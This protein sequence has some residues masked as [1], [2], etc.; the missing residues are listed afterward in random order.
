MNALKLKR[1]FSQ[2][3]SLLLSMVMPGL[4]Q[5]YMD[6]HRSALLMYIAGCIFVLLFWAGAYAT[7]A[8]LMAWLVLFI[9]YYLF[10]L[11]HAFYLGLKTDPNSRKL[12]QRWMVCLTAAC[13]HFSII[14]V[15]IFCFGL[16]VKLYR[17][18]TQSMTP[19]LKIGDYFLIDRAID[20][21]K[22]LQR[23]D[24]V[25]FASPTNPDI[26]YVKRVVGLP[27]EVVEVVRNHVYIQGTQQPEPYL[28]KKHPPPSFYGLVRYG[29][30]KVPED[31]VY[32]LGDNRSY[33]VDS[34]HYKTIDFDKI[35]G[36]ALYIVW[37]KDRK[38]IGN[39][40]Y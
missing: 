31:S 23:G 16:P 22:K 7:F 13:I 33:S 4:G 25:V 20:K 32:V 1:F 24:V 8:G 11:T 2:S 35:F 27:G 34:R 5:L 39:P 9:L 12:Y 37:A 18:P 26:D 3:L 10:N 36:K 29:P 30:L 17:V 19:T 38:R 6:R 28:S 14:C 15:V 21:L 40:V